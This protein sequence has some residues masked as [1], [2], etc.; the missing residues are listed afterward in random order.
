MSFKKWIFLFLILN[1]MS[2]VSIEILYRVYYTEYRHNVDYIVKKTIPSLINENKETIILGDSVAN[3]AFKNLILKDNVLDLTSNRAISIAGNYFLLKRYLKQNNN[4]KKVY[5]FI[6]PEFF[7]NDLNESYTYLFFE[8]VFTQEEEINEIKKVIPNL[9]KSRN[10]IDKY[11]E[12]RIKGLFKEDK[13]KDVKRNLFLDI[14]EQTIENNFTILNE[15]LLSRIHNYKKSINKLEILST[16]FLD[17]F[18]ELCLSNNIE[19][20]IVLEPIP[21]EMQKLFYESEVYKYMDLNGF[22]VIDV[23]NYYRF[24]NNHFLKDSVHFSGNINIKFQKIIDQ[25]IIDIF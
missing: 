15:N 20:N 14:N 4:P 19:F 22:R 13:Y 11:F 10:I 17:K 8:T 25:N 1:I 6:I 5:L 2:I 3:G 18:Y 21:V 23:N 24:G 7:Q 9:Y 12:R 16:V